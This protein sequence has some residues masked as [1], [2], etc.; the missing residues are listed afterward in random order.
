MECAE[1]EDEHADWSKLKS[2]DLSFRRLRAIDN[3]VTLDALVTLRLDNNNLTKIENLGHLSSLT[4]LDLSYNKISCVEGLDSL[5]KL[6]DLSLFSNEL[7]TIGEALS[8]LPELS[9]LSIGDNNISSLDEL[10]PLRKL[11]GLRALTACGNP[12]SAEEKK[13]EYEAFVLA[14][15]GAR[16]R[17]LDH[18]IV[19]EEKLASA[20]EQFQNELEGKDPAPLGMHVKCILLE[21]SHDVTSLHK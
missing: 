8:T 16:L 3:L 12:C 19:A 10:Q 6:R 14:Y 17:Y 18:R 20:Q 4:W 13:D 5:V 9:V 2:L 7:T 21:D 15:I 11:P 1:I